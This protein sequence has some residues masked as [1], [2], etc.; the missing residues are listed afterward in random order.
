MM[1]ECVSLVCRMTSC[2]CFLALTVT[3]ESS[4]N[5]IIKYI[6]LISLFT[7]HYSLFTIHFSLFTIILPSSFASTTSPRFNLSRKKFMMR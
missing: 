3:P 2:L 1:V 4:A 6:R 7:I 5:N